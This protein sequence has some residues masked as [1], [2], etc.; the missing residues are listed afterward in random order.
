MIVTNAMSF[1]LAI[2]E[3]TSKKQWNCFIAVPQSVTITEDEMEAAVLA[4]AETLGYSKFQYGYGCKYMNV[5][6]Y[7]VYE[8][9]ITVTPK[10]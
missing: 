9:S 3:Y 5:G 2:T 10:N 8:F 4:G 1:Y 7:V 6:S